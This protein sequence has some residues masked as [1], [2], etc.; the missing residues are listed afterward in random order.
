MIQPEPAG[1]LLRPGFRLVR[2]R[3]WHLW[4]VSAIVAVAILNI[5]DQRRSEPILIG[6]AIAGFV[7]YAVLG[8]GIWRFA[9]R[10]QSTKGT[11]PVLATYLV[12]MAVLF[13]IATVLYLLIEHVY[14]LGF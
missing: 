8:W 9:S 5:Q 14:L 2:F 13:L 6:L 1:A 7:L 3:I 4:L 10:F 11:L 12:T